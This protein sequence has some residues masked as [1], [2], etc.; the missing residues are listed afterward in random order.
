MQT[1]LG[2]IAM[3][4]GPNTTVEGLQRL[5][6]KTLHDMRPLLPTETNSSWE[7]NPDRSGGAF[8]Q[9]EINRSTEWR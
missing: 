4:Y 1:A 7:S 5:A 6:A 9:E 8:T 3:C 2:T